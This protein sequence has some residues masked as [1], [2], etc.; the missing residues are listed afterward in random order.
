MTPR[1]PAVS[2]IVP[3][4]N[5]RDYVAA[6]L[7]SL[8]E[9]TFGD[10]DAIIVDDGSTDS[11]GEIAREYAARD[12]RFRYVRQENRGLAGARN[13]GL[14]LA[15][16]RFLGLLDSDDPSCAEKLERPLERAGDDLLIYGDAYLMYGDTHTSDKVSDHVAFHRGQ[17]FD[18]LL[19]KNPVPVLTVLAPTEFVRRLG[20]FDASLRS[21]EDYDL[22]LRA[23]AAGVEFDYVNEPLAVYR[24]R[25]GALSQDAVAMAAWTLRV[26]RK[27]EHD[28]GPDRRA[29]VRRRIRAERRH[30]GVT[31]RLRAWRRAVAGDVRGARQDLRASFA[32]HPSPRGA[33][34]VAASVS[35]ALTRV[36][37][38]RLEP[39]PEALEQ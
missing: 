18:H 33:L 35:P 5:T 28:V 26:L 16:G 4:Y 24:F 34:A 14:E 3:L 10:W 9:Q 39:L 11:G 32:A 6:A 1:A 36:A 15:R 37:R 20:G 8:A 29:K 21:V 22:W 2:V 13:T 30:L 7:D 38:A 12:R 23:A 27:L 17:I 31:L 25:G 19:W